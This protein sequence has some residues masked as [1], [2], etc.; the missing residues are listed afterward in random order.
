M[1]IVLAVRKLTSQQVPVWAG[2]IDELVIVHRPQIYRSEDGIQQELI[3]R[4]NC[5]HVR[6]TIDPSVGDDEIGR[7]LD[8]YHPN[9]DFFVKE[10]KLTKSV[11]S[12]WEAGSDSLLI[13]SVVAN[14]QHIIA[15]LV[16]SSLHESIELLKT[17][18]VGTKLR[19][20]CGYG[21]YIFDKRRIELMIFWFR[22]DGRG[23]CRWGS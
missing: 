13:W 6:R 11:F 19:D 4:R 22:L 9:V 16:I 8:M 12:I 15:E 23:A 1:Y 7:E 21:V 20:H 18:F 2:T 5:P 14:S 3:T 10:D 17:F